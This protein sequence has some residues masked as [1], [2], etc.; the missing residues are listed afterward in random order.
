MRTAL[1]LGD[2]KSL[3]KCIHL[4]IKVFVYRRMDES[5]RL[6]L[7]NHRGH[8]NTMCWG[9]IGTKYRHV[10]TIRPKYKHDEKIIP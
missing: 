4:G 5:G 7:L 10:F 3:K 9:L 1:D 8:G 2:I 6:I